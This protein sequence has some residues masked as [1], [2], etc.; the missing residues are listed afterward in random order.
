ME[1]TKAKVLEVFMK[2]YGRIEDDDD[3][4]RALRA[5][6][7]TQDEFVVWREDLSEEEL[8]RHRTVVSY[9][10]EILEQDFGIKVRTGRQFTP[11]EK[12]GSGVGGVAAIEWLKTHADQ[13]P[14][15]EKFEES[16]AAW[17]DQVNR[18]AFELVPSE[19]AADKEWTTGFISG[20]TGDVYRHI[21]G[22]PPIGADW[23]RPDPKGHKPQG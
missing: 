17:I 23:N 7:E 10:N 16:P 5:S 8:A 20:F 19:R 13:V 9:V 3:K 12:E 21:Q 4:R 1:I 11:L 15:F 6:N 2:N 22:L 14:P 18:W